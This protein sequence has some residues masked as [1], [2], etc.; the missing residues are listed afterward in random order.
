MGDALGFRH[1]FKSAKEPEPFPELWID[2]DDNAPEHLKRF[3][4]HSDCDGEYSS[5][6]VKKLAESI[7]EIETLIDR[8][9]ESDDNFNDFKNFVIKS[10][11]EHLAWI[12][13]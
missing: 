9:G 8:C 10:A 7:N 6:D 1:Y 4:F 5:E 13:C 11:K 12:F 2:S 3:F